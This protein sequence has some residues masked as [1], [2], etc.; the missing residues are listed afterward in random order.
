M[1]EGISRMP[2]FNDPL[3]KDDIRD[4]VLF[5][6]QSKLPASPKPTMIK[7]TDEN[8]SDTVEN[9]E[10]L[11]LLGFWAEWVLPVACLARNWRK[12]HRNIKAA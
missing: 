3:A 11:V 4:I 7:V 10:G 2:A 9:S 1:V 8:F 12:W 5:L 6:H